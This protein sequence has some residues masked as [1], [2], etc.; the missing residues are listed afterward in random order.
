[1]FCPNCGS[2]NFNNGYC[3][4][5]GYNLNPVQQPVEQPKKTNTLPFIIGGV[6][7]IVVAILAFLLLGKGSKDKYMG[8][9]ECK[10]YTS[11]EGTSQDYMV[12]MELN[13]DNTYRF[14]KYQDL[15]KNHFKGTYT[16]SYEDDKKAKYNKDFYMINF[17]VDEFIS[18]GVD[19]KQTGNMEF[20]MEFINDKETL[21]I[22]A[23]TLAMYYCYKR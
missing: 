3:P 11:S 19:Q 8:N 6:V 12:S 5:C 22:N 13:S 20:E 16:T 10:G 7:V 14:G 9:W 1:M 23:S 17:K 15:D 21:I 18:E 4:N 2:N